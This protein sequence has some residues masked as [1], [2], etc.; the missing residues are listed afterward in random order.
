[1]QFTHDDIAKVSWV[2]LL[3]VLTF[4][5]DVLKHNFI[6]FCAIAS[7]TSFDTSEE[8]RILAKCPESNGIACS[9]TGNAGTSGET[10]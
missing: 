1:M 5:S 4:T 2:V 3:V 8:S 10:G 6:L 7:C 9:C